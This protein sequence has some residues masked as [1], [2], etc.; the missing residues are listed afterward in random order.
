MTKPVEPIQ[1]MLQTYPNFKGS[2]V[3]DLLYAHPDTPIPAADMELALNLQI[4]PD[5]I[6]RKRYHFA[7]I[8]M[9]DEQT[10]RCVDKRLNR[11]IELK[12]FNATTAYDDEIQA[13]IRYRKE[14]TL[15]TGKIKCFNDDDSKAY[16]RLR[17]DIDTLLKQAEKDG[18]S[19]AVAIVKRCMRRG[20][21]FVWDSD[22]NYN[23][24]T[25][26]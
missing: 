2:K 23:L 10:L 19:E 20:L 16:D 6:N 7:P 4:P 1:T 24:F 9:T 12:A 18:Y 3:I 15:P 25:E 17:K 26:R 8:R 22:Y 21:S 13:L 11:L 14:T 5:F